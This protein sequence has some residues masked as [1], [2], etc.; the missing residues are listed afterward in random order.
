MLCWPETHYLQKA[1]TLVSK[2]TKSK[3]LRKSSGQLGKF[4]MLDVPQTISSWPRALVQLSFQG[5]SVKPC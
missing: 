4:E 2:V 5:W 1:T 3:G